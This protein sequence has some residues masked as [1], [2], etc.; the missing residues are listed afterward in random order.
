M[1]KRDAF[2]AKMA[3]HIELAGAKTRALIAGAK[4]EKMS[5]DRHRALEECRLA[6]AAAIA[7]LR[8]L[9][10]AEDDDWDVARREMRSA[11][12]VMV[13]AVRRI[14]GEPAISLD[15]N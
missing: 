13:I 14:T 4:K 7:K 8:E 5:H 11:W 1:S 12:L 3:E 15:R 10:V 6:I 2:R 9:E